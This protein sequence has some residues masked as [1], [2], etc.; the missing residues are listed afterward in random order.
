MGIGNATRGNHLSSE[1][2]LET[3]LETAN[4]TIRRLTAVLAA[5][6]VDKHRGRVLVES[7]TVDAMYGDPMQ[8]NGFMV[9]MA[10]LKP[11]GQ[12]R[13]QVMLPNGDTYVPKAITDLVIEAQPSG[14]CGDEWHKS[15]LGLRCPKCGSK[16]RL[17]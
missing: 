2:V 1:K 9:D 4:E 8:A 7:A 12:H 13:L 14:P 11:L 17:A 5:V 3:Q 10:T 16:E 6:L 15:G